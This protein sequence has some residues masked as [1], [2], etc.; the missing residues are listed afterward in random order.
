MILAST[1]IRIGGALQTI[2]IGDLE[3][4]DDVNKLVVYA[5]EGEEYL[6]FWY[7]IE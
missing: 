6:T 7:K 2:R 4:I 3:K 1:G 5:G